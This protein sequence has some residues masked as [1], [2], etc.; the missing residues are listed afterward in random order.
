MTETQVGEILLNLAFLFGLTYLAAIFLSRLR[1]PGILGAL[2]VAMAVHYTSLGESLLSAPLYESFSFLAELGVLFLLFYIGLQIDLKEMRKMGGDIIWCTVLNTAV[3]FILGAAVMLGL[4]YGWLLAFVIGLTRMPTAEAVIVP[5]L[6]EFQLIRTRV[7]AFII[8][9]GTLDDVIEVFLVALVSVWIG[10][11]AG[12]MGMGMGG[13]TGEVMGIV[14]GLLAFILIAWVCRQWLLAPLSRWLPRR[15]HNL[16]ALSVVVL[17][18]FGGLAEYSGLGVVVGAI[19]AGMLMRPVFDSMGHTGEETTQ[20]IQTI[21]YG[22]FGLVFFFWVGLNADLSGMF[23][24][25]LLAVLLFVAA[26]IGKL[27]GVFFMVPMGRIN[28]HEAWTIGTGI[29]ARLTTG[30]IVAQMLLG[31]GLIDVHLFTAIVAAA[32][33]STVLVPLLFI[34]MVRMWGDELRVPLKTLRQKE[35]KDGG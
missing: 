35:D 10:N 5:I 1:I 17:F 24:D 3:P 34:L 32:S 15:P 11:K 9:A 25:P 18:G 33:L 22:F 7:G 16:L 26:F 14:L 13:L 28:T 8:G 12:G 20:T 27:I 29:N 21:S 30:I 2:F 6:D 19:T 31:A 23:T 4:G